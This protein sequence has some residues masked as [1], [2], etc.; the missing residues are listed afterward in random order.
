[1]L[2]KIFVSVLIFS[3][4]VNAA[5]T[6]A[7]WRF[8]EGTNGWKNNHFQENWYYDSSGN[9]NYLQTWNA[10]TSPLYTNNIPFGKIL[11][12]GENN[13]LALKFTPNDDLYSWNVP[14]NSY[15]F[16]SGWTVEAM[17]NFYDTNSYQVVVG[18]DGQPREN[19]SEDSW[20][21]VFSIKNIRHA[22]KLAVDFIDGNTNHHYL[23][24]SI[25]ISP[26]TWYYLAVVCDGTSAE[27]YIKRPGESYELQDKIS[28]IS[29]GAF[30]YNNNAWTVGRGKWDGYN[31]DWASAF[32]D[33]VRI[34]AG[35]VALTNFLCYDSQND[36]QSWS[37]ELIITSDL[38]SARVN[39]VVANGKINVLASEAGSDNPLYFFRQNSEGDFVQHTL[40]NQYN[41]NNGDKSFAMRVGTDDR[42]RIAICGPG[43]SPDRDHLIF[44]TET[45]AGSAIFSWEEIVSSNHWAN[46]MGFC[47]DQYNNA[48]IAL[49][50]QPSGNC[51]VFDN[52]SGNWHVHYFSTIDPNYPR[53]ALAIDN[54]NNAWLIF[55]GRHDGTNYIELW[56]SANGFWEFND[57]LTNAPSGNYEG[58]YFLQSIA[59]FEFK[60]DRT[61]VFAMKPDW[62]SSELQLW[63]G[64]SIPE[65]GTFITMLFFYIY[66]LFSKKNHN[67]LGN[68]CTES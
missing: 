59:G 7:Y 41:P 37:T 1:M 9:G 49:K 14:I 18:K 29:G 58:C 34:S 44:G 13:A 19:M 27:F 26:N 17:V 5:Q 32:I 57:Y 60:S 36:S 56:S 24:S 40:G 39:T 11:K 4:G 35:A 23:E 30:F 45:Y 47:L 61:V 62:W 20:Y 8:E 3:A 6:I 22:G 64:I 67:C 25:I 66:L 12:T 52:T 53:A 2:L 63:Q 42:I 15:D 46:Q 48:Y 54:S 68:H 55:N 28:D 21:P 33:E 50:H 38:N 31:T 43:G 16:S 51:A 10:D 65:P